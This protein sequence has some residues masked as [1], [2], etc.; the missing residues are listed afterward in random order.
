[1]LEKILVSKKEFIDI[2]FK[3]KNTL[4]YTKSNKTD[5]D[6]NMYLTVDSLTYLNN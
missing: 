4:V 1:M 3:I 2:N 5:V 6:D